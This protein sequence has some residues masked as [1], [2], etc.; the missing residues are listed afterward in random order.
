MEKPDYA[1]RAYFEGVV[2]ALIHRT[3]DFRGTEVHVEMYDDRLVISSPGGI[4]G[5]GELEPLDDGSYISKRRNPI[6]ADVFSRL[7]YMERRGSRIRKILEATAGLYGYTADKAPH[8]FVN[9]Q[10]DFFLTIS[11][12]NY[13][14]AP[15]TIHDT[16][17]DKT[18]R[19]LLFC[20]EPRSREEMMVH[21]GLK[22]R[23]H[24]QKQY[25]RPLL[26]EGKIEM[27]IPDKPRSKHQKYRTK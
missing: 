17:H 21:I 10:N 13:P 22:S 1:E 16:I 26:D 24:F 12:V 4:Y 20:K 3:Y 11:N 23:L 27:T 25:L 18:E 6:L 7:K 14:E 8:F 15:N 5:G 2:N 19:L 9:K